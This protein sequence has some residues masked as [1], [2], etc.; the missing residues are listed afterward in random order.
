MSTS[1]IIEVLDLVRRYGELTAVDGVSFSVKEG[2]IFGFLGPNGAGKSTT[3]KILSTLLAPSSGQARVAGY[4]VVREA[5]SVRRA[6]GLLFQDPAVDDRLTAEENLRLHCM[7]YGVPRAERKTRI[8]AGLAWVDLSAQRNDLV[9]TFSGGMRRRLE[10]AR[11]LLHRPRVLVL[12][13]P[14]TGLDPQTRR[15]LWEKLHDL[16]RTEQLTIFM[17]THYMDEA[18]NC[19]RIAIIDH[20]RLVAEGTPEA[21]RRR[22]GAERVVLSTDDDV[23]AEA[24]LRVRFGVDVQRTERGLEL[25]AESGETFL[26]KMVGFPVRLRRLSLVKPTLEDAFIALTGHSIRP[27]EASSKDSLRQNVRMRRRT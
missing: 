27:D 24:D 25:A 3:I 7:I 18:E 10:V 20:G 11:A 5:A 14:T 17:T 16:R 1:A 19:D 21:L 12:D 2:E 8:D 26:P 9:R 4:D 13:E 22:A 6:L 23:Q 15:A